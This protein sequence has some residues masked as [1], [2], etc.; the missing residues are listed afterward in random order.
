MKPD[1]RDDSPGAASP[2]GPPARWSTPRPEKLPAPTY[3][4]AALALAIVMI[5]FGI[6]TSYA[7]SGV[8]LLLLVWSLAKWIGEL[9]HGD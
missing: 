7:I 5:L 8:G 1:E 4:P 6:V 2:G 9:L 3:W